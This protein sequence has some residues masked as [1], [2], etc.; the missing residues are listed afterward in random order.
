MSRSWACQAGNRP[1]RCAI[2]WTDMPTWQSGTYD[3]YLLQSLC[4]RLSPKDGK[5]RS[6]KGDIHRKKQNRKPCIRF[7]RYDPFCGGTKWEG[8]G[9]LAWMRFDMAYIGL[10]SSITMQTSQRASIFIVIVIPQHLALTN[11]STKI[12]LHDS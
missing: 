5:V 8:L 10:W 6:R 3:T 1:R 2:C 12:F 7:D 11:M 9:S 4:V